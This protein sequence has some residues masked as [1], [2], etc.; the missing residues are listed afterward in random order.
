MALS[1]G[2]LTVGAPG[3]NSSKG[4]VYIWELSSS[5]VFQPQQRI[6]NPAADGGT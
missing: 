4:V 5:G 1:D 6:L 2:T 3:F